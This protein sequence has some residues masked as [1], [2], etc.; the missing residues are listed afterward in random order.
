MWEPHMQWSL[1]LGCAAE[2]ACCGSSSTLQHWRIAHSGLQG[3]EGLLVL[4][5]CAAVLL[6]CHV[7]ED[8]EV[9]PKSRLVGGVEAGGRIRLLA[10]RPARGCGR[11]LRGAAAG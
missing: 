8:S 3:E 9:A 1:Q 5:Y 11:A 7:A 4:R 2:R 6:C 10:A